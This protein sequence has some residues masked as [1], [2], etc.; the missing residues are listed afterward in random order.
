MAEA[1]AKAQKKGMWGQKGPYESPGAYK[2]AMKDANAEQAASG[3]GT[4][5]SP[6]TGASKG[7]TN[8]PSSSG[9]GST[10]RSGA[11][12]GIV[13]VGR[14]K[15]MASKITASSAAAKRNKP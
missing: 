2:K 10:A 1:I 15:P 14:A 5:P 8:K 3:S 12:G 6:A 9:A 7:I 13:V 11:K 4:T